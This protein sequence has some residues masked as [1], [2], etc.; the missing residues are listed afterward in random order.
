MVNGGVVH[1]GE[2]VDVGGSLRI[3][4]NSSVFDSI[5]DEVRYY[6]PIFYTEHME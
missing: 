6:M 1:G 5:K 4:Y 2:L 3:V